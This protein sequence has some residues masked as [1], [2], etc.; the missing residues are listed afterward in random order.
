MICELVDCLLC[1][2]SDFM[3]LTLY[4]M[5]CFTCPILQARLSQILPHQSPQRSQRSQ[6]LMLLKRSWNLRTLPSSPR[7]R[8]CY[9]TKTQV[10]FHCRADSWYLMP[11][12]SISSQR[13]DL[14]YRINEFLLK[15]Q[16]RLAQRWT[17][18][19][20]TVPTSGQSWANLHCCLGVIRFQ[21]PAPS[22][23]QEI[24]ENAIIFYF[25]W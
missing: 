22:H 21:L 14:M 10:S 24:I 6:L 19:G 12:F 1:T 20:T 13:I 25:L 2:L 5:M 7:I 16:C 17:D 11:L 9:P 3:H 23:C 4:H 8:L 15:Q 18:V